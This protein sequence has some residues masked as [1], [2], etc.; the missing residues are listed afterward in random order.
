VKK[1][2][3][4]AKE[5]IKH[6]KE[7]NK[8]YQSGKSILSSD[9]KIKAIIFIEK[10]TL[11]PKVKFAVTVSKKLGSAVWRNRLKRLFREAYRLNKSALIEK[12]F[13]KK[14]DIKIVLSS[15]RLNQKTY[16][17]LKL[18][19]VEPGIVDIIDNINLKLLKS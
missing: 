17:R 18:T 19:D 16:K 11:Q 1:Y 15:Y 2:G 10:I 6:Q 12:C 14:K 8:V 4:S 9:N 3:L 7:L 5:K 13:A